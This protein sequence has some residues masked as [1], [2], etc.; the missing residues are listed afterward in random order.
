MR[1]WAEKSMRDSKKE[2]DLPERLDIGLGGDDS[3]GA[4][5]ENGHEPM[6]TT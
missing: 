6:I 4:V 1:A 5:H 3:N 2:K